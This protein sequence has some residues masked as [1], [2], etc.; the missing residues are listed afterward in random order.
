MAAPTRGGRRARSPEPRAIPAYTKVEASRYLKIPPRTLHDWVSGNSDRGGSRSRPLVSIADPSQ[1]LLSFENMLELHVLAAL[2][3]VHAVRMRVIRNALDYLQTKLRVAR[4]LIDEQMLTDGKTILV[5]R[6]DQLIDAGHEGQT[7]MLELLDVHL[8]RIERNRSGIA[9]RLFLYH[10]Q[11]PTGS[12]HGGTPTS[13]D[14]HRSGRR[15][16]TGRDCRF[17]RFDRGGGRTLQGRGF[18]HGPGAGLWANGGGNRGSDPMRAQP[19]G[20]LS[21]YS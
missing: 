1:H 8:D 3:H 5:H 17:A 12:V 7:S 6:L 14:R 4:P 15:V 10:A 16:R 13:R 20:S 19:Q 2:R 9:T 11:E 21:R 18:H